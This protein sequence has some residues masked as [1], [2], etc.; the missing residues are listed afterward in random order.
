[1]P[2]LI[3][4][5]KNAKV[6]RALQDFAKTMDIVIKEPADNKSSQDKRQSGLPITFAKNPDVTALAGI[7]ER[8]DITIEELRK[9]AWGDRL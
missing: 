6:L 1:M 7:W 4:K 3:I 5:Y 9:K 8:R 2:E